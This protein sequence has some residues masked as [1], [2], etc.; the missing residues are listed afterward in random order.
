VEAIHDKLF[1]FDKADIEQGH[2]L[3]ECHVAHRDDLVLPWETAHSSTGQYPVRHSDTSVLRAAFRS[4]AEYLD[5]ADIAAS[6]QTVIDSILE[7]SAESENFEQLMPTVARLRY[8]S[9]SLKTLDAASNSSKGH[10]VKAQISSPPGSPQVFDGHTTRAGSAARGPMHMARDDVAELI[11]VLDV[12]THNSHGDLISAIDRLRR[13]RLA[14]ATK[15][16]ADEDALSSRF[17]TRT[18]ED[19]T[20]QYVPIYRSVDRGE[21]IH[22]GIYRVICREGHLGLSI[23]DNLSDLQRQKAADTE[24]ATLEHA[25]RYLLDPR[26]STQCMLMVAVPIEALRS[27][28]SQRR[29]SVVLRSAHLRAK[30]RLLIEVVNYGEDDDTIATRRA[31]EELRVHSHAVFV[32]FSHKTLSSFQKMAAECKRL[33]A[34]A[35]GIDVSPFRGRDAVAMRVMERAFSFAKQSSMPVYIDGIESIAVLGRAVA[36]GANYFCAPTLRP[37][38]HAPQDAE[39]ATLDD[40]YSTV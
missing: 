24:R 35:I 7:H 30:R 15:F 2:R 18:I 10:A 36:R 11:S 1:G 14:R 12:S 39:L 32:R 23:P 22:Q 37:P 28:H 29:F 17:D 27:P 33:G 26:T 4:E 8:L 20:F 38:Q 9:R 3:A 19:R 21:R 25:I 13:E 40:L 6:A 31:I 16:L 5:S 34:H